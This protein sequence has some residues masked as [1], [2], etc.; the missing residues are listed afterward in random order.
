MLHVGAGNSATVCFAPLGPSRTRPA[1]SAWEEPHRM[2][3]VGFS[4]RPKRSL[5]AAS[6]LFQ[7]LCFWK[8]FA[9][10][11]QKFKVPVR[12][13]VNLLFTRLTV[14]PAGGNTALLTVTGVDADP[15]MLDYFCKSPFVIAVSYSSSYY[16]T[17]C[18]TSIQKEKVA[19]LLCSILTTT[20]NAHLSCEVDIS[21][22]AHL[23]Q[24]LHPA[25][26][27]SHSDH[28]L[29]RFSKCSQWSLKL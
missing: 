16:I 29:I 12:P 8:Q 2:F 19:L 23:P 18:S 24:P 21:K 15:E 26:F 14:T 27:K 6:Q 13:S 9:L 20:R 25:G 17:C 22:P 5:T 4:G 7:Q 3:Q 10:K 11:S 1:P 28:L